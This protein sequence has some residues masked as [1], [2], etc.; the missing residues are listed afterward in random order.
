MRC[1]RGPNLYRRWAFKKHMVYWF[2]RCSIPCTSNI[3]LHPPCSQVFLNYNAS[4]YLTLFAKRNASFSV[5]ILFSSKTPSKYQP[6]DQK[7]VMVYPCQGRHVL[8][9][10]QISP[11]IFHYLWNAIRLCQPVVSHSKGYF[12]WLKINL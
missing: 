2:L 7:L 11:C 4:W 6:K 3:L 9:G 12:L 8:L 5:D 1:L 10:T